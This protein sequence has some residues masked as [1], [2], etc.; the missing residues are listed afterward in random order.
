M[1]VLISGQVPIYRGSSI[2][3]A[4]FI[5]AYRGMPLSHSM[6]AQLVEREDK[7]VNSGDMRGHGE[8]GEHAEK[9]NS[10]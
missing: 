7:S 6:I 4:R 10:L 5:R 2:V 1:Y 3:V 8:N 9:Y